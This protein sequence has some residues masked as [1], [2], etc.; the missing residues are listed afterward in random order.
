[1]TGVQTCALPIW[2]FVGAVLFIIGIVLTIMALVGWNSKNFGQLDPQQMM[3]LTIPAVTFM[4]TG[5]QVLFGSFF[6]R[7]S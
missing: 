6:Y 1:M 4:V 5:V 2:I 7:Y 3:R